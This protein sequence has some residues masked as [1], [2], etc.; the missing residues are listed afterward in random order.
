MYTQN[1]I[2]NYLKE[3][4]DEFKNKYAISELGL[5]GSYAHDQQSAESD[6]DLLYQMSTSENAL[7]NYDAFHKELEEYFNCKVDLVSKKGL[8]PF[9]E[10]AILK[11]VIY[12]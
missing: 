8:R 5:F 3:H 7:N 12:V 10:K 1:Q 6:I 9:F 4:K 11:D 2:L